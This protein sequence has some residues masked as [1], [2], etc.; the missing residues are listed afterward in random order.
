[1]TDVLKI[2]N[3]ILHL[4]ERCGLLVTLHPHGRESLITSSELLSFNIHESP[5]CIYVKSHPSAQRHCIEGQGRVFEKCRS[6]SFCGTCYAGVR[7]YVYP[8]SN[9][10]EC[11]G[12]I[13][14]S[15]YANEGAESYLERTSEKYSIPHSD[16][17]RLYG[18]LNTAMPPKEEIDTLISP[19]C[20][21]LELA[22]IKGA[23]SA[24]SDES[25]TSRICAYVKL[26][27]TQNITLDDV[28]HEFSC[29]R[30]HLSHTFK[31]NTGM[32]FREY[33]AHLRIED[34]KSL[35]LH[36]RLTVTEIAMSVGFS[37]SNYFSNVFKSV[38]GVSPL[39]YRKKK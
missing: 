1:M 35:L 9:G 6:G 17:K 27:H 12:F 26:N 5:Y 34:A 14:V 15:G 8:I 28:C 37:D 13:S 39:T 19:L 2:K 32:G 23:D 16:L 36:S 11:V 7:E 29:S 24:P 25:L 22:Y 31:S 38:V 20:D 10:K 18:E 21:M 4:K 3:Y 33:L 30:S